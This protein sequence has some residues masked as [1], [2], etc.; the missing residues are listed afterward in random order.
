MNLVDIVEF[1]MY[2]DLEEVRNFLRREHWYRYAHIDGVR[3]RW[4]LKDPAVG[5]NVGIIILNLDGIHLQSAEFS[6]FLDNGLFSRHFDDTV[7]LLN[8]VSDMTRGIY[9]DTSIQHP[10]FVDDTDEVLSKLSPEELQKMSQEFEKLA[11]R[12]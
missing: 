12:F 2:D 7:N 9:I 11:K 8:F 3:E 5:D 10:D 4:I 1:M 6:S